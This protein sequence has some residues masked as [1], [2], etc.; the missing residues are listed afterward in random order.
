[1]EGYPLVLTLPLLIVL[2]RAGP[3]E[4]VS[5]RG[6]SPTINRIGRAT[7]CGDRQQHAPR[8]GGPVSSTGLRS[9]AFVSQI[10][11]TTIRGLP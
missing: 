8:A 1:M 5:D 2:R 6:R 9:S 7:F 4:Q 10:F 11:Q 3:T